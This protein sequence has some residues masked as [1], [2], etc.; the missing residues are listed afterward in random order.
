MI[1]EDFIALAAKLSASPGEAERRTSISRSYYGAFHM[2]LALMERCQIQ[3][4]QGD[5]PHKRLYQCLDNSGHHELRLVADK[6]NTLR[7][8]RNDADYDLSS[9][10]FTSA[11]NVQRHL[12]SAIAVINAIRDCDRRLA[13]LKPSLR[14]E[15]RSL[16]LAVGE[17]K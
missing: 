16:G 3:I 11:R 14:R 6:L 5:N 13:S 17:E 7:R 12:Q 9:S 1:A 10:Y 4:S 15:A 2:A 8:I